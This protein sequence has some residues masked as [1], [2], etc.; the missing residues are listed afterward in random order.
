[1][2]YIVKIAKVRSKPSIVSSIGEK[3]A[4]R[5]A[6][7]KIKAAFIIVTEATKFDLSDEVLIF[8]LSRWLEFVTV[9][10]I[11][12]PYNTTVEKEIQRMTFSLF[13]LCSRFEPSGEELS[14]KSSKMLSMLCA[15]AGKLADHL[16]P[17]C[18]GHD[19]NFSN[20]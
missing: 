1:L 2:D 8:G 3:S 19:I 12:F 13:Y 20:L 5:I 17:R 14:D 4:G 15:K 6:Q 16:G 10:F 11:K 18:L 7:S 9:T